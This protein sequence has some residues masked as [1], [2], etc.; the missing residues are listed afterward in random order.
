MSTVWAA[1]VTMVV[2]G[3]AGALPALAL[4]GRRGVTVALAPLVGAIDAAIAAACCLAVGGPVV[5]WFVFLAVGEAAAVIVRWHRKPLTNPL[6]HGEDRPGLAGAQGRA[7]RVLS[8][9][10]ACAVLGA[11]AVSLLPLRAP[12]V[13]FDARTIWLLHADWFADGHRVALAA[14]QNTALPF[15]H[16]AYPPLIGGTVA[17]SWV[18]TGQR[19]ELTGAVVIALLNACAVGAAAWTMIE[20]G[21]RCG[22]RV[23]EV[24]GGRAASGAR[25]QAPH[26]VAVIV[27]GLLVLAAFGVAGPFATN[28]YADLLWASAAVGAVGFG[29]V[30]PGRGNDLGAAVVLL[31]VAGLTKDEGIATAM[32][33]VVLLVARACVGA[34]R[35]S[36]RRSLLHPIAGGLCGMVALGGWPVLMIALGAAP[37]VATLGPADGGATG[38]LH[39]TF[40]AM[41][42]H[43]H[44]V[45]L[46]VIVSAVGALALR[47]VRRATGVGNDGWAWAALVAGTAVV[48]A[49]YV[50]GSGDI[51]F[52]LATSVHRTTMFPAICAWWI[53]GTWTVV[54]SSQA[55]LAR[56]GSPSTA[57][58]EWD[59]Y[60]APT[61]R[62]SV[63]V[64][65]SVPP[66][67]HAPENGRTPAGVGAGAIHGGPTSL[68]EPKAPVL[69]LHR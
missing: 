62:P 48:V 55:V 45:L 2:L 7:S 37:N 68:D 28:G 57:S 23:A 49:V 21:R 18:L 17:L 10:G 1:T 34:R 35:A 32:A 67:P 19:S 5:A 60:R 51:A 13:G 20:L 54:G 15:A 41:W 65:P 16:S 12:S 8:V 46:A 58:V 52:W 40:A 36:P 53:V 11:L 6:A 29:L 56:R 14:L 63:P 43:L 4:G 61:A 44:V 66:R 30:L 69:H 47:L 27:A 39:A 38:R 33:I 24:R 64:R 50:T 22:Q 26:V 9:G 42:P 59:A 3:V 31:G 25:P